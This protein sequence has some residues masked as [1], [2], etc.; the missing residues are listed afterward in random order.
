MRQSRRRLLMDAI[1]SA[2]IELAKN[3]DATRYP[4]PVTT[5]KPTPEEIHAFGVTGPVSPG[6]ADEDELWCAAAISPEG[7]RY[8][9]IGRTP[10]DAKGFTWTRSYYRDGVVPGTPVEVSP[11]VPDGWT[12][13]LYAPPK[14]QMLAISS[15]AIFG[16]V[17]RRIPDVTLDEVEEAIMQSFTYLGGP[18]Q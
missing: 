4:L 6:D 3:A 2:T 5:P 12:F 1:H 10:A 14:P 17:R 13:E 18:R 9:G 16:L 8:W 7:T 11:E 15:P